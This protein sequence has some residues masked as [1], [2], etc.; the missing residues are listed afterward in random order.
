MALGVGSFAYS[1][2]QILQEAGANVGT[3]LTRDYGHYPP[4]MAGPTYT[5]DSHPSPV[6]L[7]RT[8]GVQLVIPQSIDWARQP[9]ADDLQATGVGILSP[10]GEGMRIERERDFAQELCRS[11]GIPF[12]RSFVAANL[13]EARAI[14]NRHTR[15]YVI[16]NPL[17]SPASP[18]HT[19]VCDSAV[20][21]REWLKQVDFA[22]GVFLQEYAG[23]AEAGHI[24]LVSGGDVC[25]FV[26]NQEYK[27]AFAGDQGIVAGAPLG[28]LV[29]RDPGDKYGLARE[30]LHPL[31]PWFRKV[32]Y[33]GPIQVTAARQG[34]RWTVLEYNIRL[35]VTSGAML[36]RQLENPLEVLLQ[37]ARNQPLTPVFRRDRD[38]G[39]SVTLAGYGYPYTQ[40]VGPPMPV[41][42]LGPIDMAGCD[43]WWN[44]A[45][46][47]PD[48]RW[49]A[50]G[51]RICDVIGFGACVEDAIAVAYRN[52]RRLHSPGSYFRPDIG[53]SLWP[54][55][56]E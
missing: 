40:V 49:L 3:Y 5:R 13:D 1:V 17:C 36:L 4:S 48:G 20:A 32:N 26:T 9:W 45:G 44:E 25:S 22:E 31:R 18:V 19:I 34:G 38:F 39:C 33:H 35:G 21:T 37:T 54:P 47:S 50:L 53:Q 41:D 42:L 43:L 24:A 55:G 28:G 8:N 29:E 51:H 6:P 12:P 2:M 10:T 52:I 11:H 56:H 30:L 23:K 46:L 27:R 7:I 16:K 14:I 15:P